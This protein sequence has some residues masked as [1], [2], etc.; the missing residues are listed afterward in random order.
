MSAPHHLPPG[1]VIDSHVHV[2]PPHFV[3]GREAFLAR[4]GWF[5]LLY[6]NPKSLLV[7]ADSL[8]ETMEL[9]GVTH[10][11]LCGFPW[12]DA[13]LCREHNAYMADAVTDHPG[14]LSWLGIVDPNQ[15]GCETDAAWCFEHGARGLGEFN[16]DAQ[17]FDW[18]DTKAIDGVFR[19]CLE[20]DVPVLVHASEAIGHDYPGKGTATPERLLAFLGRFPSL[21]VIGA[22]WGGGLPFFELMPEIA[23]AAANVVYDCAASTYLYRPRIFRTVIDIVGAERVLFGS[24]YPVLRMDRF[25]RRVLELDWQSAEERDAVLSGN[26]RRV[27]GIEMSARTQA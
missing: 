15:S 14:R 5:E 24:D 10:A 13:G 23:V 18:R 6:T 20:L 17:R 3:A 8:I 25:L 4:D 19:L 2:F 12:S 27:F 9:A 7:T 22:H 21:R 16:A 11:V 26:A 1:E